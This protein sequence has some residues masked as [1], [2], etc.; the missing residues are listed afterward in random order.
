VNL[1]FHIRKE[2]ENLEFKTNYKFSFRCELMLNVS[3]YG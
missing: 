2:F 3:D 1:V